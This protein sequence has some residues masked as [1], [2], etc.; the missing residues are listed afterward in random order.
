[1]AQAVKRDGERGGW[2]RPASSPTPDLLAALRELHVH[3]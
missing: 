3:E 2:Q 1:V